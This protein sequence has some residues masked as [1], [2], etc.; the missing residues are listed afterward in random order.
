MGKIY[1][2]DK[3]SRK[4]DNRIENGL[5]TVELM[6]D[7][8]VETVLSPE[9]Q[10]EESKTKSTFRIIVDI[11]SNVKNKLNCQKSKMDFQK[12]LKEIGDIFDKYVKP[13]PMYDLEEEKSPD[14]DVY[15]HTVKV[16]P[17]TTIIK[18]TVVPK[19][20]KVDFG[21]EV[22]P[23]L[24]PEKEESEKDDSKKSE[25]DDSKI[26]TKRDKPKKSKK[27]MNIVKCD[28]CG[29]SMPDFI[30]KKHKD[31]NHPGWDSNPTGGISKQSPT[32][33]ASE[34]VSKELSLIHI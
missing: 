6:L 26:P 15:I 25:K 16:T 19:G 24:Q 32:P 27:K 1:R 28:I 23:E 20:T 18:N 17:D 10:L 13:P 4:I 11:V 33:P 14:S 3:L 29:K 9:E 12:N 7:L 2:I 30:L 34:E 8:N 31:K 22:L 5:I 21:P